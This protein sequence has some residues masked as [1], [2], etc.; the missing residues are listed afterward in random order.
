M[1]IK[2]HCILPKRAVAW[3]LLAGSLASVPA[4][5]QEIIRWVDDEGVTHFG[6]PAT[7]SQKV[8][9]AQPEA[10]AVAS[11][12]NDVDGTSNSVVSTAAVTANESQ[13]NP[14]R[15]RTTQRL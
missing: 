9:Q 1:T 8:I 13:T 11:L 6:H 5:G 3:I 2:T 10:D 7:A 14:T 4:F 12:G 15:E